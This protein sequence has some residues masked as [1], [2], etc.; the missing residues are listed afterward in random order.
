MN[1]QTRQT[2][3]KII[4]ENHAQFEKASCPLDKAAINVTIEALRKEIR[5]ADVAPGAA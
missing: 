4:A 3:E 2:M 1:E 5:E